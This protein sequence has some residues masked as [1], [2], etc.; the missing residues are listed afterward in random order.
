MSEA[1]KELFDAYKHLPVGVMFF[2]EH[3]LFL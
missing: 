3:K 1:L 2:K